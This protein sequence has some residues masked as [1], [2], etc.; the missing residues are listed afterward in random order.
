MIVATGRSTRQVAALA[1]RIEAECKQ[2]LGRSVRIEGLAIC[3]LGA[4]RCKGRDRAP[5]PPRSPAILWAGE[6]VGIRF[7]RAPPPCC[8]CRPLKL[9]ILAHGKAGRG[10]EAELV[11]RYLK[12]IPWPTQLSELADGAPFPRHRRAAG[13]WCWTNA[14]RRF[15]QALARGWGNGATRASAKL[16]FLLGPADGHGLPRGTQ[17]TW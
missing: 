6:D 7:A 3:R 2:K 15:Q 10:P 4:D 1:Q 9:H 14:A 12:R 8:G 11:E 5:V 16:R 13:R 17:P